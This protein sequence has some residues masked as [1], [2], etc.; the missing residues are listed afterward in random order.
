MTF[1]DKVY[2]AIAR[3]GVEAEEMSLDW[4]HDGP[5]QA[6]TL[7]VPG[8]TLLM[9]PSGMTITAMVEEIKRHFGG[10]GRMSAG[11]AHLRSQAP[12]MI[13]GPGE[14]ADE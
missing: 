6:V 2:R 12:A 9:L 8:S 4:H 7:M 11:L 13:E 14:K 5:R 1:R 3:S 10:A